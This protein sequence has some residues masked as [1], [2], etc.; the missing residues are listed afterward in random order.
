MEK[1][2]IPDH[3]GVRRKTSPRRAGGRD[4]RIEC[5]H[6]FK[7]AFASQGHHRGQRD[8]NAA[9]NCGHNCARD[10]QLALA[11]VRAE[12][13][14]VNIFRQ[15]CRLQVEVG[16]EIGHGCTEHRSEHHTN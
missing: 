10:Q 4:E 12:E 7:D 14:L 13:C 16:R 8:R 5:H 9:N 11:C 3:Q 15:D 6:H 2:A 1:V